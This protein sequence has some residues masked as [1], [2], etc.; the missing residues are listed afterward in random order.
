M[1]LPTL[2][3]E[4]EE[5][6]P[7]IKYIPEESRLILVGKSISEDPLAFF[8]PLFDWMKEYLLRPT[9]LTIFIDLEYFNTASSK[10]IYDFVQDIN[11]GDV[12]PKFI[13]RYLDEDE[14][15]E[16]FGEYLQ[17]MVGENFV[18]ESYEDE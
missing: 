9:E 3:I 10:M 11:G 14:D 17:E 15:L 5:Y 1:S 2:H 16:E 8:T 4:R 6:T 12:K 18:L 13:W 7:L